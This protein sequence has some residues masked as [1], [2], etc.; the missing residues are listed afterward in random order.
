MKLLV[1]HDHC[2]SFWVFMDFVFTVF[3]NTVLFAS[4]RLSTIDES[5]SILSDISFDKTDES[6]VMNIFDL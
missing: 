4:S 1:L 5:G 3:S 2:D 6:L